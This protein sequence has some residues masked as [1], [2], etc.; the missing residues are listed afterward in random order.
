MIMKLVSSF[1]SW[2]LAAELSQN[3]GG[4]MQLWIIKM[5]AWEATTNAVL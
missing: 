3:T 5:A 4:N 1:F 2:L